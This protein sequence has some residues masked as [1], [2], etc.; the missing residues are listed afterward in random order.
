MMINPTTSLT[1]LLR[2]QWP[3]TSRV[4]IYVFIYKTTDRKLCIYIYMNIFY[5]KISIYIYLSIAHIPTIFTSPKKIGPSFANLYRK[6]PGGGSCRWRGTEGRQ[7]E[8]RWCS[9][10]EVHSQ[11][12]KTPNISK[13][14]LEPYVVVSLR[15]NFQEGK[16]IHQLAYM[17]VSENCG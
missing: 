6:I 12:V 13:T 11:Q 9:V 16:H 10:P 17:D 15:K 14:I 8:V 4:Y 5:K 7:G 2:R 1:N 3:R